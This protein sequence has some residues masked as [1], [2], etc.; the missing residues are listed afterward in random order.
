MDPKLSPTV[1]KLF[2]DIFMLKVETPKKVV[3]PKHFS[4]KRLLFKTFF[5]TLLAVCSTSLKQILSDIERAASFM[6]RREND[7]VIIFTRT[8][9]I[10]LIWNYQMSQLKSKFRNIIKCLIQI[11]QHH[12][13]ILYE[14]VDNPDH[15]I[16]C[17]VVRTSSFGRVKL[18]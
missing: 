15:T 5:I 14:D 18:L 4:S 2:F 7:A 1:A 12:T 3:F 13:N 8:I 6:L 9:F 17:Q 11:F 16:L 10:P